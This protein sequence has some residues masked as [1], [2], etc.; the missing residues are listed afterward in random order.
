MVNPGRELGL[1]RLADVE[2]R[3]GQAPGSGLQVHDRGALPARR[4]AWAGRRSHTL[5]I[6]VRRGAPR[7]T[8]LDDRE[9]LT[10]PDPDA[11]AH[12]AGQRPFDAVLAHGP[13]GGDR[14]P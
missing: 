8:Q 11:V 14:W 13:R 12:R 5:P 10:S 2:R 1:L 4:V 7:W 9:R 3:C 6:Y